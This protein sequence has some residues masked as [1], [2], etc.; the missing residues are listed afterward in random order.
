VR[1]ASDCFDNTNNEEAAK[2]LRVGA[3]ASQLVLFNADTREFV[4]ATVAA[5]TVP[6]RAVRKP[7]I[8]AV[9][10]I[11][12]ATANHGRDDRAAEAVPGTR[13]IAGRDA[14]RLPTK[15]DPTCF[16]PPDFLRW[17]AAAV[18]ARHGDTARLGRG[19]SDRGGSSRELLNQPPPGCRKTANGFRKKSYPVRPFSRP[20]EKQRGHFIV[21]GVPG[22]AV[23]SQ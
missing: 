10:S 21:P 8:S 15:F 11:S 22:D 17:V 3:D 18:N 14:G 20:M 7:R 6:G 2:G 19:F 12:P 4:A 16:F 9:L 13:T 1:Q 5:T 23:E